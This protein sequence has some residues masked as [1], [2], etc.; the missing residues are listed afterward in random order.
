MSED[1]SYPAFIAVWWKWY[2]TI[3]RAWEQEKK[4]PQSLWAFLFACTL[5]GVR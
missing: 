1:R 4:D 5:V 2:S 3:D